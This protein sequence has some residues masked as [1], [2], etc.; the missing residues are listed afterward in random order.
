MHLSESKITLKYDMNFVLFIEMKSDI[1][2]V[3]N[4]SPIMTVSHI[5]PFTFQC[6]LNITK[7][8][9]THAIHHKILPMG[10]KHSIPLR[11]TDPPWNPTLPHQQAWMQCANKNVC[12]VM[13]SLSLSCARAHTHAHTH[14]PTHPTNKNIKVVYRTFNLRFLRT[15]MTT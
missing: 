9:F 14:P 1:I 4:K 2:S 10:S 8:Y 12:S 3:T 7:L 15:V 6:L 13:Y 5:L 11:S